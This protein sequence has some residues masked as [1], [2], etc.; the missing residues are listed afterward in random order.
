MQNLEIKA[1]VE[2]L[3]P[4]RPR[5]R[6]LEG[7]T[8]PPPVRQT[9]WYFRVRKGR[10]KLRVFGSNREGELIFYLRP[11]RSAPRTSNFQVLPVADAAGMRRLLTEMFGV[12]V[13]VRKRREVWLCKNA[14]IHL[15][16]VDGLGRFLEIEV[17]VNRGPKQARS[18]MRELTAVL[19]IDPASLIAG[20]YSDMLTR[21]ERPV[22]GPYCPTG[23]SS[24]S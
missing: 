20:S 8:R 2:S 12:R 11:N 17:I 18:L 22:P 9:D 14:R 24:S 23:S 1:S 7:A 5:L 13:C 4:F 10:L 3:A 21:S 16:T 19:G 15:D 6:K